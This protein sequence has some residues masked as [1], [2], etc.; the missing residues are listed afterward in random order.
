MS[1]NGM[2]VFLMRAIKFDPS[3]SKKNKTMFQ[4]GV[5]HPIDNEVQECLA[6][7]VPIRQPL[8]GLNR[9]LNPYGVSQIFASSFYLKYHI[10]NPE[11]IKGY[12]LATET[13]FVR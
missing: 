8:S 13:G 4:G 10:S 7:R 6:T 2:L 3:L 1:S 12:L 5:V 9:K 11:A